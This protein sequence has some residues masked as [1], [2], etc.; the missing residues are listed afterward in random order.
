[1]TET[2]VESGS[3]EAVRSWGGPNMRRRK[4]T[5]GA[6]ERGADTSM[7]SHGTPGV[8]LARTTATKRRRGASRTKG[9]R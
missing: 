9:V 8:R 3:P 7:E 4:R 5:A 1:M 6:S 2:R